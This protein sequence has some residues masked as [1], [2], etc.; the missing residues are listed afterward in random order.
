MLPLSA[1]GRQKALELGIE[2]AQSQWHLLDAVLSQGDSLNKADL[3]AWGILPPSVVSGLSLEELK[4]HDRPRTRRPRRIPPTSGG[5]GGWRELELENAG[6]AGGEEA[7]SDGAGGSGGII[8]DATSSDG[9]VG[10]MKAA[11]TRVFLTSQMTQQGDRYPARVHVT[12]CISCLFRYEGDT[13][14]DGTPHGVGVLR[15]ASG[16]VYEGR[17]VNGVMHGP[18]TWSYENGDVFKGT[19]SNGSAVGE[20]EFKAADGSVYKVLVMQSRLCEI[21][22]LTLNAGRLWR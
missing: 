21:F 16:N 13:L 4:P 7:V 18:G 3:A 11:E 20:A 8:P 2:G 22:R 1:S 12:P 14:A 9:G 10:D 6:R 5:G 17:F 15:M 19:F